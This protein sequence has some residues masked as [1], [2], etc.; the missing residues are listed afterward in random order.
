[1]YCKTI[2]CIVILCLLLDAIKFQSNIFGSSE[3]TTPGTVLM[4][5]AEGDDVLSP[6]DQTTLRSG[7]GKLMY[8]M[9][10]SRINIAQP[11]QD[12]A[13][14]MTCGDLKTLEATRRCMIYVLCTKDEGPLLMPT[15]K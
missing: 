10:Y 15:Q 11:V 6:K 7:V 14:Y 8:Q 5:P 12:L 4:C 13:W 1:M 2:N 9:Q 3:A